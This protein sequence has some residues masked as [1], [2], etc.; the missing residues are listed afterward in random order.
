MSLKKKHIENKNEKK[1]K[2]TNKKIEDKNVDKTN[3]SKKSKKSK[4]GFYSK[5]LIFIL[6]GVFLYF[7]VMSTSNTYKGSVFQRLDILKQDKKPFLVVMRDDF[8]PV[9]DENKKLIDNIIKKADQ[10]MMVFDISYNPKDVSKESKYFIDKFNIESL[11]VLILCDEKGDLIN[12][13]Y[14]PLNEKQ[15]LG[16]LDKVRESSVD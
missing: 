5:I 12:S 6:L 1:Y 2:K 3:T 4:L 7:A 10:S 11:P 9:S 14:I 13:Y 16:S 8:S 15:I